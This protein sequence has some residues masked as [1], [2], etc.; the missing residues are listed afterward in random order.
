MGCWDLG[1]GGV[2][3]GFGGWT[4]LGFGRLRRFK[5]GIWWLAF[6]GLAFGSREVW[7]CRSLLSRWGYEVLMKSKKEGGEAHTIILKLS[8]CVMLERM[9][10][11]ADVMTVMKTV[12][13]CCMTD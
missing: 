9:Q 13:L 6:V 7:C 5:K 12:N 10:E 11:L 1:V 3:L 8:V 2:G 4:C